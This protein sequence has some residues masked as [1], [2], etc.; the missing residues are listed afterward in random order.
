MTKEVVLLKK[1]PVD[2]FT[3]MIF[4]Q[5]TKWLD[6]ILCEINEEAGDE[7]VE[8]FK[9]DLFI[10]FSGQL[11]RKQQT[12]YGE[13]LLLTG[14]LNSQFVT[15]CVRTGQ[16]MLDKIETKITAIFLD[17]EHQDKYGYDEE[18]ELLYDGKMWD[19]YFYNDE[20]LDITEVIHEY[21]FLN[22]DPY[23]KLTIE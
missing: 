20:S 6:K 19:L 18:V 23:P 16:S 17:S 3:E 7:A 10:T 21:L 8:T 22:K 5:E 14:E 4:D 2:S 13:I 15:N 1:I 12:Q 9:D 11:A